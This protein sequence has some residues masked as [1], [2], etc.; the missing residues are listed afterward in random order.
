MPGGNV[1]AASPSSA[2][3]AT[4]E[5]RKLSPRKKAKVSPVRDKCKGVVSSLNR[6]MSNK[7]F[8]ASYSEK[9]SAG[10]IPPSEEVVFPT[11]HD[12]CLASHGNQ[13]VTDGQAVRLRLLE[14]MRIRERE[15]PEKL[16]CCG[17]STIAKVK[18]FP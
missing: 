14:A 5:N 11:K 6:P 9:A 4:E 2:E 10:S 16:C 1:N 8:V 13:T 18:G 15:I 3:T 12:F 17:G 7:E